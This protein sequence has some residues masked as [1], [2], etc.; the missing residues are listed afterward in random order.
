[1]ETKRSHWVGNHRTCGFET[2][3]PHTRAKLFR[4]KSRK[5]DILSSAGAP[6]PGVSAVTTS[7]VSEW[8]RLCFTNASLRKTCTALEFVDPWPG[9]L[10]NRKGQ[11][12]P[13]GSV[14]WSIVLYTKGLQVRSPVRARTQAAGL[15]LFWGENGR[16]LTCVSHD[17]VSLSLFQINKRTSGENFLKI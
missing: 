1:M 15:L 7:H 12:W 3:G 9:R 14:G 6:L 5:V 10:R 17:D 11:A 8:V 13:S 2:P 16:Q 4:A